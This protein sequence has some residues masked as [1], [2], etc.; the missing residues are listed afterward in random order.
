MTLEDLLI[1]SKEFSQGVWDGFWAMA[2]KV[3]IAA[4]YSIPQSL[5]KSPSYETGKKCGS[6]SELLFLEWGGWISLGYILSHYKSAPEAIAISS[7][8]YYGGKLITNGVGYVIH[9]AEK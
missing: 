7:G 1:T 2:Y 6:I 5:S 3:N 8:I 9:N 4:F